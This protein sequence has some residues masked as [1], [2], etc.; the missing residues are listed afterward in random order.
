MTPDGTGHNQFQ[1]IQAL[2]SALSCLE[3]F[4]DALFSMPLRGWVGLSVDMFSQLMHSFVVLFKLM[5]IVEDGWDGQAVR[6]RLDL[7]GILDRVTALVPQIILETGLVDAPG[8]RSGI[9]FRAPRTFQLIKQFL[10]ARM[11]QGAAAYAE[12][13]STASS[14]IPDPST[15]P[16]PPQSVHQ[17]PNGGNGNDDLYVNGIPDLSCSGGDGLDIGGISEEVYRRALFGEGWATDVL[18]FSWD[19]PMQDAPAFPGV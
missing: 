9:I 12:T 13:S 11:P 18:S 15:V 16:L 1:R 3:R 8:A 5:V 4:F 14:S 19:L 7:F 6:L 10:A 2:E 17:L